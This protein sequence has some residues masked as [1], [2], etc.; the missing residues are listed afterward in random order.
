[1]DEARSSPGFGMRGAS[2]RDKVM[3]TLKVDIFERAQ[4][5]TGSLVIGAMFVAWA[6]AAVLM[7]A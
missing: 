3:N 7:G 6:A 4:G 5:I 1:L 2:P